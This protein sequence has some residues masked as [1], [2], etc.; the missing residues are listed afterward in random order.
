MST[1]SELRSAQ[2]QVH[3]AIKNL[4]EGTTA[5][6]EALTLLGLT[7]D[8]AIEQLAKQVQ[9]EGVDCK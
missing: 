5:L 1:C 6:V 9:A 3:K 2:R 7:V 8:V 4:G